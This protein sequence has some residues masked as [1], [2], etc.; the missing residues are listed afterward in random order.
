M[1]RRADEPLRALSR[2]MVQ[3]LAVC[4]AVLHQPDLLLLDEPRADLDPAATDLVERLIG[5]GAGAT[6][7]ITGHDPA[8]GLEEAD[9]ALGLRGGRQLLFARAGEVTA[10][11][12]EAL[13]R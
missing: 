4:R 8:G 2:G 12:L 11:D 7:V 9:F 5:R 1:S 10:G 6:R 3:R 13:Y